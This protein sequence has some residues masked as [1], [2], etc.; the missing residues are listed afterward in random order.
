MF[1]PAGKE[2]IIYLPAILIPDNHLLPC[3]GIQ[4]GFNG[5]GAVQ[6]IFPDK[7]T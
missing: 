1:Q 2:N 5:T 3:Q 7:I 4:C 6:G